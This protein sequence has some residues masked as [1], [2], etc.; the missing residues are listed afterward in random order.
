MY[1]VFHV[2]YS[3]NP[4][5]IKHNIVIKNVTKALIEICKNVI[6]LCKRGNVFI[7]FVKK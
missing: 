4:P 7:D 6:L 3:S 5:I 2:N 1:N